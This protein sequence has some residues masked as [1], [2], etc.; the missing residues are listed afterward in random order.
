MADLVTNCP[1][2]IGVSCRDASCPKYVR[3]VQILNPKTG[4]YVK[5]D[6][7]EGRVLGG[8]ADGGPYEG[9]PVVE[10]EKRG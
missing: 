6:R 7:A 1:K 9:I 4:R 10:K 8:K 2:C 3:F 5:V